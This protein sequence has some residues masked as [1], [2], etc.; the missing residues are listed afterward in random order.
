LLCAKGLQCQEIPR[1]QINLIKPLHL[2]RIILVGVLDAC[3]EDMEFL[4]AQIPQLYLK[5]TAAGSMVLIIIAVEIT[6]KT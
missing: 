5:I 6:R 4:L 2:L 1:R 3:R